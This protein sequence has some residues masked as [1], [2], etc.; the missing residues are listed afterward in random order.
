MPAALSEDSRAGA[1]GGAPADQPRR[2]VYPRDHHRLLDR[3]DDLQQAT[4]CAALDVDA[5]LA[6]LSNDRNWPRVLL[7]HIAARQTD[8]VHFFSMLWYQPD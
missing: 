3:S 8:A 6:L 1:R 4:T 5:E 2:V 7:Q